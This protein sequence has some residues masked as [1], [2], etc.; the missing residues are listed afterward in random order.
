MNRLPKSELLDALQAQ[1]RH[2]DHSPD[3]G[4]AE[5]VEVIRQHILMRIR[6][7]EGAMR[8]P[9][10]LRREETRRAEAA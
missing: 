5:A 3:F 4:D 10:W 7:A 9:A 1:L 8:R 2:F 6:E